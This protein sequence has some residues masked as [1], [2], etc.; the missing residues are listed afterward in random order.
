MGFAYES[1]VWSIKPFDSEENAYSLCEF[2]GKSYFLLK[3]DNL[4]EHNF[5][6]DRDIQCDFDNIFWEETG[7]NWRYDNQFVESIGLDPGQKFKRKLA[8]NEHTNGNYWRFRE[9]KSDN[10]FMQSVGTGFFSLVSPI[11]LE[12]GPRPFFPQ[13]GFAM[14]GKKVITN[15]YFVEI[16]SGTKH[17]IFTEDRDAERLK[18][19]DYFTFNLTEVSFLKSAWD[20]GTKLEW[21][22][23]LHFEVKSDG[24]VSIDQLGPCA[25]E[26]VYF[27]EDASSGKMIG[28][29]F[30]V[31][32]QGN[33]RYF[34][35]DDICLA[36]SSQGSVRA[37]FSRQD[38]EFH[39]LEAYIDFY[40][41]SA[42]T[43]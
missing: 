14:R 32:S 2:Y 13:F 15:V 19:W 36:S 16:E 21:R 33:A 37:S 17:T 5:D 8:D 43:Q 18:Q 29:C 40:I 11:L 24:M 6:L 30:R 3:K 38:P 25:L 39:M 22:I 27:P 28:S 35:L 9:M 34:D 10:Y 7:C 42:D 41:H 1:D 31:Q 20:A 4:S 12:D 26:E 23:V